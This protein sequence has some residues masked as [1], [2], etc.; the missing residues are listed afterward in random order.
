[1]S[2]TFILVG[3]IIGLA[4]AYDFV[5]GVNDCANAIA[6]TVSTRALKPYQAVLMAAFFNTLGAFLTTAVAKTIG[7]GIVDPADINLWIL[8]FALAGAIV[9]SAGC[10]YLGI[11]ISVTH[12][13]VGGLMGA[14]AAAFGFGAWQWAGIRKILIAMLLSPIAGFI[15]AYFFMVAVLWLSR[16]AVPRKAHRFFRVSQIFS[17]AGMAFSHGSN[18]TQNA[19]GVI[20][21]ALVIAGFQTDFHVPVWVIL[22]SAVFMGLGTQIGGWRIIRTMGSRMVHLQ[23]SHGFSAETSSALVI[24]VNSWLGAPISTTQVIATAIM[25]VGS[26]E[27]VNAVRW[28]LARRIVITWFLTIPGAAAISAGFYYALHYLFGVA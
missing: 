4:W 5:N 21:A 13:M 18:D 27:N 9:W 8:I 23:P 24:F 3:V 6:T 2:E 19:M 22:G 14:S 15:V 12:A 28:A 1:M 25:G 10:S 11:P 17:A 16:R 26:T 20:T 7:K